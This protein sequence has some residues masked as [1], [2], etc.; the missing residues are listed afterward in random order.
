[1]KSLVLGD[2]ECL[3]WFSSNWNSSPALLI[4]PCT[5]WSPAHSWPFQ[6]SPKHLGRVIERFGAFIISGSLISWSPTLY[7][8]LHPW[9]M[10]WLLGQYDFL[11]WLKSDLVNCSNLGVSSGT[12]SL[13]YQVKWVAFCCCC[14]CCCFACRSWLN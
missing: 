5:V 1:M 9:L 10:F 11:L 14:R 2:T 12:K 8:L 3:L 4:S 6:C 7:F 13:F